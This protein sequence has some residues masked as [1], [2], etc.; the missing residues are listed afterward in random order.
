MSVK[1]LEQ[2]LPSS[3]EAPRK[4]WLLLLGVH[5]HF[6]RAPTMCRVLFQELEIQ[7]GMRHGHCGS[8]F[9]EKV[10]SLLPLGKSNSGFLSMS[11]SWLLPTAL[12]LWV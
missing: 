8:Q 7:A 6:V 5:P 1:C 11:F 2:G 4:H 10:Y 9:L 3:E 12:V